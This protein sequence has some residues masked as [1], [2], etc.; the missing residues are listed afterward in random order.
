MGSSQSRYL[1]C[2]YPDSVVRET[3]TG[4]NPVGIS[5]CVDS[6]EVAKRKSC[7]SLFLFRFVLNLQISMKLDRGASFP[8]HSININDENCCIPFCKRA[9][10]GVLEGV[11]RKHFTGGKPPDPHSMVDCL[12]KKAI[13]AFICFQLAQTCSIQAPT[14]LFN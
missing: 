14:G 4:T 7:F 5:V 3:F 2:R 12:R 1:A 13:L 6:D 8:H 10:P 11:S 9:F